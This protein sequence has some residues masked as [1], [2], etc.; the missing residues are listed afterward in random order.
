MGD[1][2]ATKGRADLNTNAKG[3]SKRKLDKYFYVRYPDGEI[4]RF[5][6]SG[7]PPKFVRYGMGYYERRMGLA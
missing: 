3:K 1:C 4:K 6:K 2:G 5:L 7:W